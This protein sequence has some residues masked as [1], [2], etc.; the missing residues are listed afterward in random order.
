MATIARHVSR[1]KAERLVAVGRILICTAALAA[2][3][4]GFAIHR[5]DGHEMGITAAWWIFAAVALWR[6]R[7]RPQSRTTPLA[8][9]LDFAFIATLLITTGGVSSVYFPTIVMPPFAANILYGKRAILLAAAGGVTVYV[10]TLLVTQTTN[11][12]RVVI[13]RFGVVVLLGIVVIQRAGY[14]QRV[15][16]DMEHLAT[17]PHR[18]GDDRYSAMQEL[19]SRAAA[20]LRTS[21]AAAAWTDSDGTA[22]FALLDGDSFELDEESIDAVVTPAL[23]RASSFLDPGLRT[24]HGAIEEWTGPFLVPS[25]RERLHTQVVLGARFVSQTVDGWLFV[26]DRRDANADDLM[27]AEIVARLMSSGMD[28]VNLAAMLQDNAAAAERIRLSRDLHDGL[29]QSLSGLALHAQ[30]ARRAIDTDPKGAQERLQVVVEQLA[31]SQRALRDFVDELRP[32]LAL[33]RQPLRARL[34]QIARRVEAQWN[35][36]VELNLSSEAES[37]DGVLDRHLESVTAEA[38]TNAAKHAAAHHVRANIRVEGNS[39][40]IDVVDDGRGFPF[41][42]RHDLSRLL[43]EERGPWS[44]KERVVAL[45]GDLVIDSSVRGSRVE[46]RLPVAS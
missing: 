10:V 43:A 18:V 4:I 45:G 36:A 23:A 26:L 32:E 29:L 41:H 16:R 8:L 37:L 35:V 40:R 25:I 38:I 24:V 42:G 2:A 7:H 14:E 12:P 19:L 44:L 20:T 15:E 1:A 9:V 11:D 46:V 22:F 34:E 27:L 30:G 17:W 31:E 39:V 28:Q 21:R 5:S 6:A 3:S 33:R 13:M